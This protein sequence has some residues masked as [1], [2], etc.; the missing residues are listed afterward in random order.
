MSRIR[1]VLAED[2]DLLRAGVMALLDGYDDIDVVGT[3]TNLPELLAATRL[4]R[5]GHPG[6]SRPSR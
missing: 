3:A 6:S 5:R 1:V 4:H 2:G